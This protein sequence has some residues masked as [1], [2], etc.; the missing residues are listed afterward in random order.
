MKEIE[1]NGI[2]YKVYNQGELLTDTKGY[3]LDQLN[4]SLPR[5]GRYRSVYL[6]KKYNLSERDYYIIVMCDGKESN[7]PECQLEGCSNHAEFKGLTKTTRTP[8]IAKG[9]CESHTRAINLLNTQKKYGRS[10]WENSDR[11]YITDDYRQSKRDF[12]LNQVKNG[13]HPWLLK[14]SK[15]L[16]QKLIDEG[17]NP[18]VNMWKAVDR[19]KSDLDVYDPSK[20]KDIEYVLFSEKE[21]FKNKENP[22]DVCQFYIAKLDNERFKIGVTKNIERRT[23]KN[24]YH[25]LKYQDPEV[26]YSSNRLEI[27]ELEYL[28]KKTFIKK[29]VLGTE[30]Y[31]LKDFDEIIDFINK[32]I[33]ILKQNN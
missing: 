28:V 6:K 20:M 21:S 12:A 29:V 15:E 13:T 14:N 5:M 11:S 19:I 25:G 30:T 4:E 17:K 31:S 27:A 33:E 32:Q 26:L 9:C 18:I 8:I 7:L 1:Y 16:R 3:L 2:T 10:M 24:R 22:D 23:N